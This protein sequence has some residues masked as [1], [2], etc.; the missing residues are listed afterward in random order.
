[1]NV[2]ANGAVAPDRGL[3]AKVHVANNL[4]AR[5]HVG[6]WV[7][8]WMNPTKRSNH[9]FADSNIAANPCYIATDGPTV[10]PDSFTVD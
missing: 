4:S 5:I 8:L 3:L 6:C 10:Y 1:V 9:D 7:N 2:A